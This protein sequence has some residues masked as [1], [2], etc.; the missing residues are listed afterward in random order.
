MFTSYLLFGSIHDQAY[1]QFLLDAP[2]T[3]W[4]KWLPCLSLTRASDGDLHQQPREGREGKREGED[5][6][7]RESQWMSEEIS[8]KSG[9]LLS[10]RSLSF[11]F[12]L[13]PSESGN[14]SAPLTRV[15]E[16]DAR[17]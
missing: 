6:G 16:R 10:P 2:K 14:D 3:V 12:H 13:P 8:G 5:F 15:W 4:W 11:I 1:H 7:R 17:L 9:H